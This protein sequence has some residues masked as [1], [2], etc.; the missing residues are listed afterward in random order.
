MK[1]LSSLYLKISKKRFAKTF[2]PIGHKKRRNLLVSLP[3]ESSDFVKVLPFIQSLKKIGSIVLLVPEKVKNILQ[4]IKPHMY[5][6]ITYVKPAMVLSKEFKLIKERLEGK[7]FHYL[8]ELN[9]PA[10]IALP[11]LVETN[12]RI[13]FYEADTYPYYN[14]MVK[15][16]MKSLYEFFNIQAG[17]PN[18]LFQFKAGEIKKSV[19]KLNKKKPLLVVNGGNDIPWDHDRI[20]I[21]QD[22]QP[23]DPDVYKYVYYADAYTGHHDGLYELAKLFHKEILE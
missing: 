9:K 15:D 6:K 3:T 21:G 5:E 22:V 1:L 20:I 17:N 23:S 11:Y 14:I 4:L 13:C 2:K 10:N 7:S 8:I 18:Y 12:K 16:G 19:K